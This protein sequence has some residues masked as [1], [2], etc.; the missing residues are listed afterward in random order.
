MSDRTVRHLPGA[1]Y[2]LRVDAGCSWP[3]N[4][5]QHGCI[6]NQMI[7]ATHAAS[8]LMGCS[9]GRASAGDQNNQ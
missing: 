9:R 7:G 2:Q 5:S 6:R 4:S 3:V 8:L 1:Q